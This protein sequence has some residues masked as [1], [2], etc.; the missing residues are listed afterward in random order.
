M[1]AVVGSMWPIYASLAII[2]LL[3]MILEEKQSRRIFGALLVVSA[4][5]IIILDL[6]AG[7]RLQD[8]IY[9]DQIEAIN[10]TAEQSGAGYPPQGVGSPDP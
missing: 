4:V 1:P 8:K 7:R 10:I 3:F 9:K 2:A 5:T 6:R